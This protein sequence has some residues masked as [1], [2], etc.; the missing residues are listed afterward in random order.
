MRESNTDFIKK[1]WLSF[2]NVVVLITF[3]IYQARWQQ[4]VDGELRELQASSIMHKSDSEKHQSVKDKIE[5]FVPRTEL[6]GRLKAIENILEKIE[7]KL[8]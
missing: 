3:I 2:S 1:N 8:D 4:K 6:D 5:M 7:K